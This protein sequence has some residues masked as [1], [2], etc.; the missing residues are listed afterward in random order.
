MAIQSEGIGLFPF[1][2]SDHPFYPQVQRFRTLLS[3]NPL[4]AEA[5]ERV[6]GGRTAVHSEIKGRLV[7]GHGWELSRFYWS[8]QS[9]DESR[10]LRFH[11]LTLYSAAQTGQTS[12]YEFPQDP[13]LTTVVSFFGE[14]PFR[15]DEEGTAG[16]LDVLQYVP[17]R[18]LTFRISDPH[19]TIA[20]VIGK[21]KRRSRFKES[22][23]R[24]VSVSRAIRR[25]QSA[26][27]VA[28][29]V[30]ID[31]AHCLFFQEARPGKDLS[32]L[33]DK[34]RFPELLHR[35][36]TIHRDLHGQNVP[37]VPEWDFGAFLQNLG[38]DIQWISFFRPEQGPFLDDIRD[39]LL[40]QVP[41]IDPGEYSFCHGD[42]VCSQILLENDHWSVIDFD[43][44][45]RGDPYLEIAMLLASLKY[46]VPLFEA[47]FICR[48]QGESDI[49]EE[50][51]ESYLNG[52]QERA[53]K[54]LSRKRLLWYRICA[55][56]YYLSLMLKKDRFCSMAFDRTIEQVRHL[57][58]Q[59]GKD[60]RRDP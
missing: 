4:Y 27:S 32:T 2:E 1:I 55:E 46:D 58:E 29:P 5:V 23:N 39:L 14:K 11:A 38:R 49:L 34:D 36:G 52:Y 33:L 21:F 57:S 54:A 10:P 35:M 31:E 26:F 9:W 51:C 44:G 56:I 13:Y 24:L 48:K 41:R 22:Y 6:K 7:P 53:Q 12:F 25:S 42:F 15:P 28:A 20:P 47:H 8:F 59:L 50:A 18:R 3:E 17:L 45:M 40:R 30:G 16:Q 19:E 43:L 60:K 37:D